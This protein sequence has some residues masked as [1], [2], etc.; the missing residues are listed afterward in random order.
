M[1]TPV[2][3]E[4]YEVNVLYMRRLDTVYL[5]QDYVWVPKKGYMFVELGIKAVNLKPGSTVAVP[6]QDIY[7]IEQN[8]DAW[9]PSWGEAKAVASGVEISP[10]SLTF[11]EIKDKYERVVF[12]EVAFVRAIYIVGDQRPTTLL[13]GFGDSPLIAVDVP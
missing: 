6:W 9:Y 8:G 5:D 1:G 13:F 10:K 4:N 3:T 12:K 11:H 7:V 2:S